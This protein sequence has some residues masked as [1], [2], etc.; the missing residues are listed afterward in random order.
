MTRTSPPGVSSL[1]IAVP[2]SLMNVEPESRRTIDH[3]TVRS[4]TREFGV[5]M[6][7]TGP[8]STASAFGV[9][10]SAG[11]VLAGGVA[12]PVGSGTHPASN[13]AS[14]AIAARRVIR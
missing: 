7:C 3:G 13:R 5:P 1:M 2:R 8:S 10:V 12:S 9:A 11:A 14:A 6:G 4:V